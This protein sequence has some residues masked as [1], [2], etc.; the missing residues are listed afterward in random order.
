MR[1]K[2]AA[3]FAESAAIPS[4]KLARVLLCESAWHAMAS[5][6]RLVQSITLEWIAIGFVL[7]VTAILTSAYSVPG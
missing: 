6:R 5:A 7:L 4:G 2:T 3:E 1:F